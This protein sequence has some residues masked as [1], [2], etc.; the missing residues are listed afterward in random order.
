VKFTG[1]AQEWSFGFRVMGQGNE[2]D[3]DAYAK[4]HEGARPQRIITKVDP[5]EISPVLLGAGINTGTLAVKGLTYDDQSEAALAAVEALAV[6]TRSLADLR[7]SEGRDLSEPRKARI[8]HWLSRLSELQSDLKG[9][10]ESGDGN[11]KAAAV[12][13]EFSR[14][15][16]RIM[17]EL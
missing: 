1:K 5:Y 7:R 6:R 2:M 14:I 3:L 8:E 4:D 12:F 16:A 9:L 17:E 13:L 15:N 11:D 10:L